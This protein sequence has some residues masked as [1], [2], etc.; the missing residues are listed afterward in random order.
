MAGLTRKELKQDEFT[1]TYE[2][3]QDYVREHYREL[4]VAAFAAFIVIG[5]LA[6]WK[7]YNRNQEAAANTLLG[8]ALNSFHAYVGAAAPG[9][10]A[11]GQAS[12]PTANAKYKKAIDQFSQVVQKY[13]RQR[14]AE[15]ARYHIGICQSELGD[16][17]AAI[18]TLQA[19]SAA[20]D[21]QI[22]ALSRFALAGVMVKA[23]KLND[24][25]KIYED[26]AA[27]PTTSVPK[28]TAMLALADAYRPTQPAEAR[29]IY[30]RMQKEFAS[31]SYLADIL[32]QQMSGL[33]Q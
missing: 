33:P 31:D 30:E 17:T 26:L 23:G 16:N 13:P 25:V 28:A 21:L 5:A 6:G 4:I 14:A 27:H 15:I 12:F 10:L 2:A 7:V 22:R 9:A 1:S 20:S 18:K 11:P 24:A 3:F 32:K 19:A 29:R 8:T